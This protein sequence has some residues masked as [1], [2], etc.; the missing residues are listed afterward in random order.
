MDSLSYKQR[1]GAFRFYLVIGA[2]IIAGGFVGFGAKSV[3]VTM[4]Q[5][6]LEMLAHS[7]ENLKTENESLNRQLN[8]LGVELEVARLANEK[9]QQLIQQELDSKISLRKQLSFYQKVMA[10]E[11]EQEGFTI[12]AFNVVSTH[13]DDYYR[14]TLVLMQFDKK[15]DTVKGRVN[16]FVRGSLK[17]KPIEYN[18]KDLMANQADAMD[19]SFRYFEV[20]KGEFKLPAEFMPEKVT[21]KSVLS[22]AKWG[23]RNLDKS[24]DWQAEQATQAKSNT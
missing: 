2:L 17:G 7:V 11:L 5:E 13:S 22:K 8:I 6:K 19:F 3:L 21:V 10:P 18:L 9:N 15:R 12:D 16:L 1:L 24:F 14:F 4:E 20:L 23:K